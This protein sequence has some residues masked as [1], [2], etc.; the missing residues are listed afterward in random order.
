MC[1]TVLSNT[2]DEYMGF[3][4]KQQA[5]EIPRKQVATKNPPKVYFPSILRRAESPSTNAG[6]IS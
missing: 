1:Y 6:I 5:A 3:K 4:D 2:M